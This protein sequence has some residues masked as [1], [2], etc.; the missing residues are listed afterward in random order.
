MRYDD[1]RVPMPTKLEQ[2][3]DEPNEAV[4]QIGMFGPHKVATHGVRRDPH[5][6]TRTTVAFPMRHTVGRARSV[7]SFTNTV[8]TAMTV[9]AASPV[10]LTGR[11]SPH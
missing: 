6:P 1:L 8:W 10:P 11:C 5:S 3:G 7:R 2:I 4:F 9:T